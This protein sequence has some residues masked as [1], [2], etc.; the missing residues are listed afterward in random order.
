MFDE[1]F[2]NECFEI[3][4]SAEASFVWRYLRMPNGEKIYRDY[5]IPLGVNF[6]HDRVFI[7]LSK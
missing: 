1:S 7:Y 3:N 5:A 2:I 6:N 4:I